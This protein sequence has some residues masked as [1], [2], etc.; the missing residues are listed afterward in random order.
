[1]RLPSREIATATAMRGKSSYQI[2]TKPRAASRAICRKSKGDLELR[3]EGLEPSRLAAQEPKT[4]AS[5]S[6]ATLASALSYQTRTACQ[7]GQPLACV[8]EGF[9]KGAE[10]GWPGF[11]RRGRGFPGRSRRRWLGPGRSRPT[12]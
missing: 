3:E 11:S 1:M 4:C 8:A 6:S 7:E 9:W 10:Q 12:W 5:A 2:L